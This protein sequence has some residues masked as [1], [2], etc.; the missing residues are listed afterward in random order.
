[1]GT[2]ADV[3]GVTSTAVRFNSTAERVNSAIVGRV[4]AVGIVNS[5]VEGV[6]F[7]RP[8]IGSKIKK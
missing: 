7:T 6:N 8:N 4:T 5:V 1:M 2:Y 3:V